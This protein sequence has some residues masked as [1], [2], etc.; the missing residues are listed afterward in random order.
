M[1]SGE[2]GVVWV[3]VKFA[4]IRVCFHKQLKATL[5]YP[6]VTLS[7]IDNLDCSQSAT[8]RSAARMGAQTN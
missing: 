2:G 4:L 1:G 7:L 3:N 5:Q 6:S 8:L